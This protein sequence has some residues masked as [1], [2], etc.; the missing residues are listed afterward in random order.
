MMIER[1][2]KTAVKRIWLEFVGCLNPALV[3]PR[4]ER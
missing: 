2:V 1:L 3:L 4:V